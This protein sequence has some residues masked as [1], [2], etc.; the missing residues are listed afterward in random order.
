M[1]KDFSKIGISN[2]FMFGSVMSDE[3]VCRLFLEQ[4][5][6]IKISKVVNALKE[7]TLDEKI[8]SHGVRLDVWA[9]DDTN[10]FNCEM[11]C[12]NNDDLPKRSRYYQGQ[13][14]VS[15]LKP[16]Q[17]YAELRPTYIIFVCMFDPFGLDEYIYSFE[18]TEK[19]LGI[20]LNDKTYKIFL[21]V[22]GHKGDVSP[23]FKELMEYFKTS[24]VPDNCVNPLVYMLDRMVTLKREN[25]DWRESFMT[26]ERYGYEQK[27]KGRSEIIENLLKNGMTPEKVSELA[28]VPLDE[29]LRIQKNLLAKA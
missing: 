15:T 25:R 5:L 27:N 12:E 14:D 21:N 18:N 22:N 23:E 1:E 24:I 8:D 11:Q 16:G 10:Y 3:N 7:K 17:P 9:E 19:H 4:I 29:V 13:I 26:W 2:Y 28:N 6:G 20:S